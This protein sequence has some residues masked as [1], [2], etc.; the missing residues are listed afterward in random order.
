M[1]YYGFFAKIGNVKI[2]ELE[3]NLIFSLF[4]IQ[5]C[6]ETEAK[7][8][9]WITSSLKKERISKIRNGLYALVNPATGLIYADKFMLGSNIIEKGYIAYQGALEFHGFANQVFNHIFVASKN[10]FYGFEYGGIIYE[11]VQSVIPDGVIT[12]KS[13]C[14]IRVTDLERTVIDCIDDTLRAGGA[15]ELLTAMSY[16]KKLDYEKILQYLKAYNKNNLWQK[17]AYL[18]EKMKNVLKFPKVF[19]DE[20]QKGVSKRVIYFLNN[21][22]YGQTSFNKEWN[23]IA[24][25]KLGAEVLQ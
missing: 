12:V 25:V 13:S 21:D 7:A 22:N 3:K 20:C 19:F 9:Y 18:F 2:N 23:I 16:I 17:A 11:R 5:A 24:P 15:E 6:F 8:A 14:D 10:R 4:E 1:Q